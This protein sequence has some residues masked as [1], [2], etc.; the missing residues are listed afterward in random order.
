MSE[1]TL[2]LREKSNI[3]IEADAIRP[4]IF[5][6][7]SYQEIEILPIYYG[8]KE[9]RLGEIFEVRGE[10]ADRIRVI[11][12]LSHI[13]KIGYGMKGG[14][15]VIEGNV[16]M[17]L[18]ATMEG[19]EIVVEG[20]ASDWLGAEMRGGLIRVKGDAG[21][22]IGA[23]YR[24][25][26]RGMNRGTIIVEGNAGN[27]VGERM[28]RGLI[29]I[30]GDACDFIGARM[31]AGSIIVFGKIGER[32]GA[33]MKRGTIVTFHEPRLLP[34]FRYDCAYSPIFLRVYLRA[35]RRC[36][37]LEIREDYITGSYRRYNGDISELGKGEILIYERKT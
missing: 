32:P 37:G 6:D 28:R 20:N 22:L 23:A 24:G 31:I 25:S 14:G 11:G 15:I 4:D 13:K 16:G 1:V 19:G 12:D 8:N 18:G 2:I 17:H 36:C 26:K 34:T 5:A 7:K 35:L 33:G 3:P 27:E 9:R 21:N 10:K 30:L 29:V